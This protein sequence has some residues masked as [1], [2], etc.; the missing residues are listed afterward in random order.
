MGQYQAFAAMTKFGVLILAGNKQGFV[1][2]A[3]SKPCHG[4]VAG[5][6]D[7]RLWVFWDGQI[8]NSY[9]I[10]RSI[11]VW[12]LC[13]DDHAKIRSYLEKVAAGGKEKAMYMLGRLEM[14]IS[15]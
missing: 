6:D 10:L 14:D 1:D 13:S 12:A 7:D 11:N 3:G 8:T 5:V 15:K 9:S 2:W 4:E